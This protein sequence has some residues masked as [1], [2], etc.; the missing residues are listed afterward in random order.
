MTSCQKRKKRRL[1]AQRKQSS[2]G[3][4]CLTSSKWHMNFILKTASKN[5]ILELNNSKISPICRAILRCASTNTK[6]GCKPRALTACCSVI[7]TCIKRGLDL[8]LGMP[9]SGI[10]WALPIV[11]ASK[12][13]MVPVLKLLLDAGVQSEVADSE[14]LTPWHAAFLNPS[15]G[16][17]STLRE[18]DIECIQLFLQ[19]NLIQS[20]KLK[21]I[22]SKP[23]SCT[24]IGVECLGRQTVLYSS[25]V[26]KNYQAAA[27]LVNEGAKISDNNFVMLY[28][29]RKSRRELTR[30]LPI[31]AHVATLQNK[32]TTSGRTFDL[33]TVGMYDKNISWSFPPTWFTGIYEV[34]KCWKRNNLPPDVFRYY[35]VPMFSRVHFFH[36]LNKSSNPELAR[37]RPNFNV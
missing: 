24:Y 21:Y 2:L 31:V 26:N 27:I 15:S 30:L 22:S 7:Q 29:D 11:I 1:H 34:M 8:S 4:L 33:S 28:A 12:F 32:R 37:I 9:L 19:R 20:D 14:G 36:A 18:V 3:Q 35:M 16:T 17:G 13:S 25:I 23:G 6:K 10:R 5:E